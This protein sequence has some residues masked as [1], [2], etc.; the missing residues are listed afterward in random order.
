MAANSGSIGNTDS[1]RRGRGIPKSQSVKGT[2]PV[3]VKQVKERR[4]L[5]PQKRPKTGR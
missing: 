2:N 1:G 5:A 4:G 3:T